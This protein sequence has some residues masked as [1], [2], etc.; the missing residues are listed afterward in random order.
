MDKNNLRFED[1]PFPESDDEKAFEEFS[2]I[3]REYHRQMMS[4]QLDQIWEAVYH[5]PT[6]NY[7]DDCMDS[8]V[9]DCLEQL[10]E[11]ILAAFM[12]GAKWAF[13]IDDKIMEKEGERGNV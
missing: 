11:V 13:G 12:Y 1:L 8:K 4:R 6:F 2:P 9:K 10:D 3:Y 7:P 5:R